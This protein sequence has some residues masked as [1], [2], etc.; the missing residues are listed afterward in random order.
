MELDTS[1]KQQCMVETP[2]GRIMIMGSAY[3]VSEAN[4]GRDVVVNASFAGVLPARMVGDHRPRGAIGVDCGVGP[5]AAGIVGIWYL[6]ALNIPAATV[7]V[8][9]IWLGDGADMWAN[10]RIS[11]FNRPAQDCGVKKG[12]TVQ[13]AARLMLDNDPG[14]PT[15]LEVTNREVME[16]G[17]DGRKIVCTDSI[18]FGLPEDVRNI[19]VSGG[20]NGRS[21]ADYIGA[22]NPFG[23]IC[24]DGGGGRDG[25][26][27]AA[28]PRADE[29]HIAGATVDARTARM[30]DGHSTW[31]EGVISG[32]NKLAE[33]CGVRIGMRVPEAARLLVRRKD[34]TRP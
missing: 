32:A 19:I 7:D 22:I 14:E 24:S 15:A 26:G 31:N 27:R 17:P 20:H 21:S 4:R 3:Y 18:T 25:S 13:E 16:E 28:L 1:D 12:M 34:P 8:M 2:R 30:G 9:T 6:E 29:M 11:F 33:A 5:E 10:G 23:Y